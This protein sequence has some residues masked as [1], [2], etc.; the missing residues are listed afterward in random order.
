MEASN[1]VV[2]KKIITQ[3]FGL[4]NA[5]YDLNVR[6]V[7]KLYAFPDQKV[8]DEL[9]V[10]NLKEYV[11]LILN[12]KYRNDRPSELLK[13]ERLTE[14][15][16]ATLAKIGPFRYDFK[17]YDNRPT[18]QKTLHPMTSTRYPRQPHPPQP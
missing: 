15:A 18:D 8:F 7:E 4:A 17:P 16:R 3:T 5:R 2:L 12:V 9:R 1:Y 13:S 14:F 11:L 10:R 6:V